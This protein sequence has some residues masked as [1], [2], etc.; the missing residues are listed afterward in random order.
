MG[1]FAGPDVSE[2]GLVLAVDGANYKSFKGESTTN[3]LTNGDFSSGLTGWSDYAGT[4]RTVQTVTN[5]PIYQNTSKTV[6]N[7]ISRSTLASGNYGGI[8]QG[9]SMTAGVTYTISYYARSLSGSMTLKFSFQ[10]GAG[11]ENNM[12]HSNTLTSE[13]TKFT[14]TAT[15]NV[16]RGIMFVWNQNVVSGVF[17]LTDV[18]IEAKS[19]ATTFTTGTRGTT[20]ATGGGWANMIANS[21]NGELFNG[22]RE[23]S[24]N[25]GSLSFD[26]TDDYVSSGALSG[27][28]ASFTV[29]IWFY[30][31]SVTNYQNPIDCNY[32]YNGSTGNIGPRLEMTSGGALG[33][34][35]SNDA[36]NNNNFYSH[37]VVSSGLAANTWHCAAI[38]YNGATSTTYYNGNA[39]GLSRTVVGTPTG[40]VGV[41]N[42]VTIGKGFHLGGAERIFAGRVSNTQVYN[43]ALSAAEIQQNFNANRGRFG[44]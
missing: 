24:A 4:T 21:N 23:N 1:V 44:I 8:F 37:L 20:V 6:L 33:W 34:A 2:S 30:P 31:T 38:T 36:A 18:Q 29:V 13:W 9:V 35:Y 27:S 17:E 19:Y 41:M 5:I 10:S 3:I 42:N 22:V 16:A 40:F 25:S 14:Y 12:S 7:C 39:T 15:L 43:R 28:F 11:D 32:A 26:G